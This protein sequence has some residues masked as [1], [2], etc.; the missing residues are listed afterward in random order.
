VSA[1]F[2][3]GRI[4]DFI[5]VLTL[6][7]AL[8]LV[9]LHRAT[10]RGIPPA[11]LLPTLTAGACLLATLRLILA[12]AWWGFAALALLGAGLAHL[13]DLRVRWGRS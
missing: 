4:A 8:G 12:G 13:A 9:A 3:D 7:E 11:R 5:L 1:A 6:V 2:A 10:G